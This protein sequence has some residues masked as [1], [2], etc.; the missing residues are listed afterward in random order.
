MLISLPIAQARILLA[1]RDI[2]K[3]GLLK[4]T[5]YLNRSCD[6]RQIE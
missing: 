1:H 6:L 3:Y 4:R 2:E 5:Y